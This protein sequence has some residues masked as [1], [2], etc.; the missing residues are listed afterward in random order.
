MKKL[1]PLRASAGHPEA[2][3]TLQ[4]AGVCGDPTTAKTAGN[5]LCHIRL[6][7]FC[8]MGMKPPDYL[9]ALGC[10]PCHTHFDSNGKQGLKRGSEDWLFYALRG[11]ARTHQFWHEYGFLTEEHGNG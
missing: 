2:Y 7:D 3:C 9:A 11:M 1:S 5:V 10:G 6:P 8:G 4:I